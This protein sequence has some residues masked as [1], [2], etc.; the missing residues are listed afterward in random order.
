MPTVALVTE[1]DCM[2][3]PKS[4]ADKRQGDTVWFPQI[5]GRYLPGEN[6]KRS[7]RIFTLNFLKTFSA[8]LCVLVAVQKQSVQSGADFHLLKAQVWRF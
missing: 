7:V 8:W 5:K 2:I 6:F 1:E 3:V 4:S